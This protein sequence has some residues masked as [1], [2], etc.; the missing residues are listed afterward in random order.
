MSRLNSTPA[1]QEKL[2]GL[3]HADRTKSAA[4]LELLELRLLCFFR[5]ERATEPARRAAGVIREMAARLSEGAEVLDPE[6]FAL[7]LARQPSPEP[8]PRTATGTG[9]LPDPARAAEWF[10]SLSEAGRESI[11]R[12]FPFESVRRDAARAELGSS[13]DPRMYRSLEQA[14][15]LRERCTESVR[16]PSL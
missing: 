16:Q 10:Q 5:W 1:D 14:L 12:W 7:E 2:L 9:E 11:L 8:E 4:R 6:A 3:F 15:R 13:R